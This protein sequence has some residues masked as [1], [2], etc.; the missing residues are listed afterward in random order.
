[1]RT[2]GPALQPQAALRRARAD[3]NGIDRHARRFC[4]RCLE[5]TTLSPEAR[6]FLEERRVAHLAT[7]DRAARPHVVPLCYALVGDRLY[8]VVD[9]KPKAEGKRLRRLRNV[10]ENPRAAVVADVWDED[11]GRLEY[12]LVEGEAREVSDAA[13]YGRALDALRRRYPQY[14][15]M[16]LERARNAIVA[17]VIDRVHHW[18]ASPLPDR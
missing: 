11:W 3:Y 12:V 8:F 2:V 10:D 18:S 15:A 17:I 5:M 4:Y 14:R 6:A 1:V 9:E 7:A 16:A 13:E